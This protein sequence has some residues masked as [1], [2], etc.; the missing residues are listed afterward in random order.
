ML[1]YGPLECYNWPWHKTSLLQSCYS[2]LC[3]LVGT[4]SLV[5]TVGVVMI[6]ELD[7]A[8]FCMVILVLSLLILL[9]PL[10]LILCFYY[11]LF[12]TIY[13]KT[14]KQPLPTYRLPKFDSK[15]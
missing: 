10:P 6:I 7:L 5:S 12:S 4:L 1:Y 14:K 13:L 2:G 8:A 9:V 15:N 11:Q 3:L